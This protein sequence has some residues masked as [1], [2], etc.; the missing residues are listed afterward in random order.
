MDKALYTVKQAAALTGVL[1]TTLRVWERRYSVVTP[2]RSAGGYRLYDDRELAILRRMAKLV[3][4]GVP[5]SVAARSLATDAP[6]ISDSSAQSPDSAI[7][8]D[9]VTAAASLDAA[10][11][12]AVLTDALASGPLDRVADSWLL[13]ELGRLGDAWAAGTINIAHEHFVSAGVLR[14]LGRLFD[15]APPA[16]EARPVLVGLP[17]GARHELGLLTVATCLRRRGV[18]VVYLGADLPLADWTAA[19]ASLLPRAVLVGVPLNSRV[20]QAQEL[21]DRLSSETPP[22]AVWVGGGLAD[23]VHGARVL[24]SSISDTVEELIDSLQAGAS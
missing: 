12:D 11:L 4:G 10:R 8:G 15:E 18:R 17:E 6:E 13:P 9:L 14:A 16:E 3:D 20:A 19:V 5:A 1:E 22:V 2:V 24:P 23:R 7:P 21:V